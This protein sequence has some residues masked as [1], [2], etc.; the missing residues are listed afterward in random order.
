M[1]TTPYRRLTAT[2]I[3][4]TRALFA[5]GSTVEAVICSM[6][7]KVT[8]E[9]VDAGFIAGVTGVPT[10]VVFVPGYGDTNI[11]ADRLKAVAA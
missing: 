8:G 2:E 9:V 3:D 10:V 7:G 11:S 4:A 6:G 5:P 1:N